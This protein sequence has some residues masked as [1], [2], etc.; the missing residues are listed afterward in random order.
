MSKLKNFVNFGWNKGLIKK[1]VGMLSIDQIS[2]LN[3]DSV[4]VNPNG[5]LTFEVITS[6]IQLKALSYS[7]IVYFQRISS[8]VFYQTVTDSFVLGDQDTHFYNSL[9]H[10][11]MKIL[12]FSGFKFSSDV[13]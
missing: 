3:I 10:D 11:D 4:L 2:S 7:F 6:Q 9:E 8:E 13:N 12:G 5:L 1:Y